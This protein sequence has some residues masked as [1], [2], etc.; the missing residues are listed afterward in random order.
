MARSFTIKLRI[1]PGSCFLYRLPE[2]FL[3]KHIKI[4][5]KAFY[6]YLL[7]EDTVLYKSCKFFGI[8]QK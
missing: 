7:A 3:F 1:I 6:R 4:E 8:V 5:I 2:F